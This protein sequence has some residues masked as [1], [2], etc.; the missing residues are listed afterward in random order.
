MN[1]PA[2]RI[3]PSD[4]FWID[5][6]LQGNIKAMGVLYQ[7]HFPKVYHLCL[8]LCKDA[9]LAFDFTQDIFL[10]AFEHL[11][12]FRRRSTF[13]TWLYSVTY[14]HYREN[15]RKTKR[16]VFIRLGDC[17]PGDWL[18]IES[19]VWK[20]SE[21]E[22]RKINML[23]LL[24]RLTCQEKTLLILKYKDGKSIQELRDQFGL[25]SGTVKMRLKRARTKL[26]R[27]YSTSFGT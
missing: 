8:S 27:I 12:T 7:R 9:D 15:Y 4:E 2:K 22:T 23:A 17:E 3:I 14:N 20:A 19:A 26:N 1:P 16:L 18:N 5:Q 21:E 6:F 11:H 24:E 10:K 25:S 13:S